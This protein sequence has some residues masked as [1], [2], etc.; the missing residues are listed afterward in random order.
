MLRVSRAESGAPF[1]SSWVAILLLLRVMMPRWETPT[2]RGGKAGK[3]NT[4]GSSHRHSMAYEPNSPRVLLSVQPLRRRRRRLRLR[5][6][7]SCSSSAFRCSKIRPWQFRIF[8]SEA[9]FYRVRGERE[10]GWGMARTTTGVLHKLT[11][12]MLQAAL[13]YSTLVVEPGTVSALVPPLITISAPKSDSSLHGR[14][15]MQWGRLLGSWTGQSAR[16]CEEHGFMMMNF[17]YAPI[18]IRSFSPCLLPRLFLMCLL[19]CHPPFLWAHIHTLV[20]RI[21]EHASIC[22]CWMQHIITPHS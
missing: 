9:S 21:F 3:Y 12:L 16:I 18:R 8:K 10:G 17:L 20:F 11:V 6:P 19:A 22:Q 13:T 2:G 1:V 15:P 4:P 5:L 7:S 14:L